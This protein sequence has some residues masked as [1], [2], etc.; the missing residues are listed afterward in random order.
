MNRANL[1]PLTLSD[2]KLHFPDFTDASMERTD[3]SGTVI[4][5]QESASIDAAEL[6]AS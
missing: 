1:K 3:F 4:E 2:G 5:R 6:L